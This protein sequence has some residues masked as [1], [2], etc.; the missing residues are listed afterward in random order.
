MTEYSRGEPK[1]TGDAAA[2]ANAFNRF[3]LIGVGQ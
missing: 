1:P 2:L 3:H